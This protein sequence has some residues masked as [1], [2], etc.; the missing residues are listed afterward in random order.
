V[1]V[2]Y[3]GRGPRAN[4]NRATARPRGETKRRGGDPHPAVLS[5]RPAVGLRPHLPAT[6]SGLAAAAVSFGK[7][8]TTLDPAST[9]TRFSSVTGLPATVVSAFTS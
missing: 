4:P 6:V 7:V 5:A 2:L 8:S 3:A 1:R 9:I